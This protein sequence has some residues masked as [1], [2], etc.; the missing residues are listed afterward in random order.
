VRERIAIRGC[1]CYAAITL[2]QEKPWDG[3]VLEGVLSFH[4]LVSFSGVLP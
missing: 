3:V 4:D 1:V 2:G